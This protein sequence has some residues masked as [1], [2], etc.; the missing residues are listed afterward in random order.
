M[1]IVCGSTLT[2]SFNDKTSWHLVLRAASGVPLDPAF[3]S[4]RVA[5]P[6]SRRCHLLCLRVGK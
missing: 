1:T 2:K 6:K 5:G 3:I 4:I